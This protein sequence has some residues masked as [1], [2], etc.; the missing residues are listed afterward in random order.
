M[1]PTQLHQR[2]RQ[3]LGLCQRAG[4]L[5]SGEEAV[6][7]AL[8]NGTARLVLVSED[9]SE[10]TRKRLED[11]CLSSNVTLLRIGDRKLLGQAIGKGERVAI[12]VLDA[13]F[14]QAILTDMKHY[15]GG[16]DG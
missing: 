8:K 1:P 14:A 6:L 13:G 11:K 5:A 15:G 16:A 7:K 2:L 10:N 3:R 4:R 9:A 12:A